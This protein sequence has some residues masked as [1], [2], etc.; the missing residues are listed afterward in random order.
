MEGLGLE[1]IR[2]EGGG[3]RALLEGGHAQRGPHQSRVKVRRSV[4]AI[5]RPASGTVGGNSEAGL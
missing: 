1:G 5:C 2:E 3:G 4:Q